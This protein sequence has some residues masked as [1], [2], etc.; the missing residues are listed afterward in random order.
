MQ[1][2]LIAPD[3]NFARAREDKIA[4]IQWWAKP[5]IKL[6]GMQYDGARRKTPFPPLGLLTVAGLTP[7]EHE[8]RLVDEAIEDIDFKAPADLVGITCNTS[9]SPRA[10]QI[11]DKFRECGKTVILGGIHATALPEEALEHSDAVVAGEAEGIWPKLLTDFQ[12][13]ELQPIYRHESLPGL[14]GYSFP[15]RDLMAPGGYWLRNTVQTTRGC[16]HNCEF[17]SVT[18]FFGR[19][20]RTRPVDEVIEEVKSLEGDLVLFVDDNIMAVPSFA[21]QLFEGLMRLPKKIR[22]YSQAS[23]NMMRNPELLKLASRSGCRGLFIGLES[24]FPEILKKMG[25]PFNQPQLYE[26]AFAM[27]H[28]LGIRVIGAFV[29][30]DDDNPSTIAQT[31]D[32]VKKAKV[33]MVQYALSTPLPGTRLWDRVK[34]RIFEED[35]TKY[36]GRHVTYRHPTISASDMQEAFNRAYLET[37]SYRSIFTRLFPFRGDWPT[38]IAI[39]L[40][41]RQGTYGWMARGD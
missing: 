20:Y 18:K 22:W 8:V 34:E 9:T 15:R 31:V 37:Y 7:K 30:G 26:R 24:I 23:I 17:C 19:T 36:D 40:A 13:R 33:D 39:N 10:Y 28:S 38:T 1:I 6:A 25:K 4:H 21:E 3:I 29:F 2:L 32:Y 14:G 27:L 11:A 12:S 5:I 35:R 16:P 41:F